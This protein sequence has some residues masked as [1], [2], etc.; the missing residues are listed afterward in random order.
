MD[1]KQT[2]PDPSKSQVSPP[3]DGANKS[4]PL[5]PQSIYPTPPSGDTDNVPSI[6]SVISPGGSKVADAAQPS[7]VSGPDAS[8]SLTSG[9]TDVPP[10][11][12]QILKLKYLAIA[13]GVFLLLGGGAAAYFGYYLPNKPENLWGNSLVNMGKGYD[14]LADYAKNYKSDKGM[15]Y[16]G[17]FKVTGDTA[18]DGT[19]EGSGDNKNGDFKANIS[20]GGL[21]MNIEVLAIDSN[22]ANPDIYIKADGIAGIE[23]LLGTSDPDLTKALGGI[24]GQWYFI[25]HSLLDQYEGASNSDS[26]FTKKDL[27]EIIQAVEG[28][29]KKYVFTDDLRN[30]AFVIKEKVGKEKQDDRSVYH[31]KIGVNKANLK[32]YNNE[33]C[34]SLDKTKLFKLLQNSGGFTG[35]GCKDT[36]DIDAIKDADTSDVWV[37]TRTKLIHKVRF[38]EKGKENYFDLIQDYQGG[39]KAPFA[40]AFHDKSGNDVFDGKLALT[41][42]LSNN[43]VVIDGDMKSTGSTKID[44]TL[45]FT[46]APN[47]GPIK[48]EKPA[49]AKNLMQLLNDLGIPSDLMGSES[50]G[51]GSGSIEQKARD[52]ERK[53]DI[54]ALQSKV[55]EYYAIN[56]YYPVS[57]SQ[58]SGLPADACKAPSGSGTCAKPD[59]TYKAFKNG[60]KAD[61]SSA[62]NCNNTSID[63]VDYIIYTPNSGPGAMETVPNP[64]KV[65]GQEDTIP[66]NI[67]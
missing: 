44:G 14:K 56:G 1:P 4:A 64:Y 5:N 34:D 37:D 18:A 52:T 53:S 21:K 49:N 66:V 60:T 28:P 15:K 19:F 23:S 32:A 31:Y 30:M 47:D 43:T 27:D 39:N 26:Q 16:S 11:K 57:L 46:F 42:D 38:S 63:C 22:T 67:Q 35:S 17:S 54:R 7:V 41:L 62:T 2:S 45:K 48:V 55:A 3:D 24:N 33:L 58:I 29:S 25:D 36:S 8:A 59:Y 61:P 40:V 10:P 20:A 51:A 13:G 65:T 6:G 12:R 9:Q 50:L